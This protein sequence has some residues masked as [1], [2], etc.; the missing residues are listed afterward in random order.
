MKVKKTLDKRNKFTRVKFSTVCILKM[1][2]VLK[3]CE[4]LKRKI[5]LL[6]ISRVDKESI[7][8]IHTTTI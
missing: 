1:K 2:G 8:S 5:F 3:L 6:N 4:F 7:N